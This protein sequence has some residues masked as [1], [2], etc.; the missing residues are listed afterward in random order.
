MVRAL[1]PGRDPSI[2]W[3]IVRQSIRETPAAKFR[4]AS[5]PW[6]YTGWLLRDARSQRLGRQPA[7]VM[8]S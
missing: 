4:R 2:A 7:S 8:A 6:Q 1:S 5:P 3:R